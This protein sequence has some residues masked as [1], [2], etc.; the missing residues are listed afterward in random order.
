MKSVHMISVFREQPLFSAINGVEAVSENQTFGLSVRHPSVLDPPELRARWFQFHRVPVLKNWVYFVNSMAW[1]VCSGVIWWDPITFI[2]FQAFTCFQLQHVQFGMFSKPSSLAPFRNLDPCVCAG[3]AHGRFGHPI[4]N[5]F[6]PSE[7]H[8]VRLWN[9]AFSCHAFARLEHHL[10]GLMLLMPSLKDG[11]IGDHCVYS[12]MICSKSLK[13]W[14]FDIFCGHCAEYMSKSQHFHS[15][16]GWQQSLLAAYD[17]L[18]T[19][20]HLAASQSL[21]PLSTL[22]TSRMCSVHWVEHKFW[23]HID[24]DK[25]A[26]GPGLRWY[27]LYQWYC[28]YNHLQASFKSFKLPFSFKSVVIGAIWIHMKQ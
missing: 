19:S 26:Q 11:T 3:A 12:T 17:S 6:A 23:C 5:P 28:H 16:T 22:N 7:C 25:K 9:K 1:T 4:R 13:M 10:I 21:L 20:F 18:C 14:Y 8:E 24:K 27:H 2:H 15:G